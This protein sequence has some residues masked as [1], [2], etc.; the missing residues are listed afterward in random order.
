VKL[1]PI[2]LLFSHSLFMSFVSSFCCFCVVL[3]S[4]YSDPCHHSL[5]VLV[6]F[7][8]FGKVCKTFLVSCFLSN[9]F[10]CDFFDTSYI[11]AFFSDLF[12]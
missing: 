1:S 12:S 4:V 10:G 7:F 5:L 2:F 6:P 9:P 8:G 3:F 11:T